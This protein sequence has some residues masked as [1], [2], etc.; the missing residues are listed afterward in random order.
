MNGGATAFDVGVDE[1]M[2]FGVGVFV[3]LGPVLLREGHRRGAALRT[4][5]LT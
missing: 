1:V 5:T 3:F 4:A 2:L